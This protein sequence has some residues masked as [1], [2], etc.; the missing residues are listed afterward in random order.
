MEITYNKSEVRKNILNLAWPTITEQL[1]VMMVGMV[2]TIFVS[3]LG[4]EFMAAVGMVNN[5]VNFFQTIFAGLATGTTIV[6]ARITGESG[7]A[8][9]K[10]ALMQSMLMGIVIGIIFTTLGLIFAEH[11]LKIFFG[12]AE[13]KVLEIAMLY[14]K[15]ILISI[16]FMILDMIIAGALRGAGDTKTPLYVTG[17]VNII[18]VILSVTLIFGLDIWIIQVPSLGV[19]GAAIAVMLARICG[20]LMRIALLFWK[21]S[22]ICFTRRDRF[23]FMP[24]VMKRIVKVGIP[25][26]MENLIMQGGFL[27][28]QI[29]VVTIGTMQS[30]AYQIGGNIHS[31]AFMPIFGFAITTTATVGQNLGKKNY[32]NAEIY[33]FESKRMAIIVGFCAGILEFILAEPLARLYTN[34]PEVIKICVIVVR[35]FALIEPFMGI[36]KVSAAA[37]RAAGDIK[38]VLITAIVA[39]WSFRITTAFVLNRFL[40]LGI[41][42]IMIGIFLDFSVRAL[43]YIQRMKK[44]DW[45][46]LKV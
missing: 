45:K 46:Y 2:S 6:V 30:A 22:K 32:D 18:N 38:Y 5:L 14:Y 21:G 33:A 24:K 39:L 44:G 36:E 9:A 43:M 40:T 35:G 8:K 11:V 19:K 3:R 1:L 15:F 4:A 20:G 34:D 10:N 12:S 23:E 17:I 41:Y 26:F 29:M 16:P 7:V 31:L 28:I 37:M 25:S 27:V 13:L 42:G